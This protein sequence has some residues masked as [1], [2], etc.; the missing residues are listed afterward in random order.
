[1][2]DRNKLLWAQFDLVYVDSSRPQLVEGFI[3]NTFTAMIKGVRDASLKQGLI[4]EPTFDE[5]IRGLYRTAEQDGVFSYT[6][7]KAI[8][9]RH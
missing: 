8:A 1:M 5:G 3:K 9:T 4:D 7:Y 2:S 6:F